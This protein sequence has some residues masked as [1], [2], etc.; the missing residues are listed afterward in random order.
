MPRSKIPAPPHPAYCTKE[1]L[2]EWMMEVHTNVFG[3][4]ADSTGILDK[5]NL[6]TTEFPSLETILDMDLDITGQWTFSVHPYGLNHTLLANIGSNTHPQI[7]SHLGNASLHVPAHLLEAN[8]HSQYA[9][10]TDLS[11]HVSASDPHTVYQKESEKGVASGYASLASD[12]KVTVAQ[13][14]NPV[15][16][17]VSA[18]DPAQ[19]PIWIDT[20]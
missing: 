4:G 12:V 15:W 5:D 7:D 10:D 13:L 14:R 18:P 16:I 6:L 1:E 9:T 19:Y 11:N 17:G 2:Y 8:P 20:S 3:I